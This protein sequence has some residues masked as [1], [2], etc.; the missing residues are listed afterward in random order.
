MQLRF[1]LPHDCAVSL[2]PVNYTLGCQQGIN[3]YLHDANLFIT[4]VHERST[5]QA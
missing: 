1:K 3:A 5:M 4:H 2:E